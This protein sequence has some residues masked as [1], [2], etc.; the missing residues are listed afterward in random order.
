MSIRHAAKGRK[1]VGA[2]LAGML[3]AAA[4]ALAA[5][6]DAASMHRSFDAFKRALAARDGQAAVAL[7]SAASV[8]EWARDRDLALHGSRA[9]V[10]A[11]PPGR[12]LAVLA[13]R[14]AQPVFLL[15][16]GPPAELASAAVRAGLVDRA[17]LDA[18]ELGD[19]ARLAG[20]RAS[21]LVLAAGLPSGFR[22][23]FVRERGSW[24]LDLPSSLAAADRVVSQT[25][26]A[27]GL[28]EDAVILNLIAAASGEATSESI[29]R[30]LL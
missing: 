30:P 26:R 1:R 4:P 22:A 6:S 28:A 29:W 18:V 21:G 27:T 11:L 20:D 14:H 5:L 12:R 3:L 24:C 7:L 16:E 10:E 15:R 17:A 25:A 13:L 2:A 8:A 9:D 19:I 23:G